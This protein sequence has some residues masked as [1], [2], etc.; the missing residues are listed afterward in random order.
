MKK[1]MLSVL[2]MLASFS[3]SADV[4]TFDDLPGDEADVVANGYAG[5]TW[6]NVGALRADTYPDSGYAAGVVSP[7]NVAYNRDGGTVMIGKTGGFHFVG[8]YFTSAWLDQ[9][10]AF[11]GWRDGQ[12]VVS[13][14]VSYVIDTM[15][16]VWIQLGWA[17]IDTLA[18][19]NSSGT[20]WAMD[21]FTVPEPGSLALLGA[22]AAGLAMARRR[23]PAVAR[24]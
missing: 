20:Q 21:D 3:A 18:I 9:E 10:L 13:T 14:S 4:V 2:L 23:K 22:C 16:P 19:Y 8:A 11:E 1:T 7:G 5:F 6:D 12:L 24:V 17:G 15:T